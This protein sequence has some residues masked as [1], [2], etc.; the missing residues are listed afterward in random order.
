MTQQSAFQLQVDQN[1]YLPEGGTVMDAVITVTSGSGTAELPADGRAD[2]AGAGGSGGE[3]TAA[4]VIVVDCSGSMTG[5]RLVE[6]KRATEAA[7]D[8]LREGVAFAV[9]AGSGYGAMAYPMATETVEARPA[10]R[11]AAKQAVRRLHAGGGTAIG[12]W[13]WIASQVFDTVTA[14]IKHAILLTDGKN[15]HETATQL[16]QA[17][18]RCRGQFVCDARGVGSNWVASELRT[19][20]DALLGTADGLKD[21]S[22]LAADFASMTA[23]AMGKRVANVSLRLWTPKDSQIRFFKQVFPQVVELS[24]AATQGRTADY[25]TGAWGDESRDYH[26]CVEVPAGSVGSE[27]LAARVSIVVGDQVAGQ[28]LVRAVWTEDSALSTRITPQVAHY[29]GQAELASAIQEGLAARD[30]GDDDTATAKLGRAVQLADES[31]HE[32][33]AKLLARVVDV[34]D[35]GTGTIRLKREAEQVDSEIANVRSVKTVRVKKSDIDPT[36]PWRGQHGAERGQ[37]EHAGGE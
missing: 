11:R 29:T 34:V 16:E 4:Q 31:G 30:A 33:T 25:P 10:T 3:P 15:E 22:E 21:P 35:A 32:D 24:A 26:L 2:R 19:V 9:V 36:D 13:L 27:M 28:Q 37:G 6:A 1:E 5:T 12:S 8:G 23:A 20:A 7:I 18:G 17:L 14:E